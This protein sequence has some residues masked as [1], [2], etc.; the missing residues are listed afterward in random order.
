[1][2]RLVCELLASGRQVCRTHGPTGFRV[3]LSVS[4]TCLS[5]HVL[6]YMPSTPAILGAKVLGPE[7]P[8]SCTRDLV[9]LS[10]ALTSGC[11][12]DPALQPFFGGL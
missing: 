6:A 11:R 9:A 1:M 12:R 8:A 2:G 3:S 4:T 5:L 7:D 10:Y